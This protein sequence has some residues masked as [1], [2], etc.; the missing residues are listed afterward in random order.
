MQGEVLDTST[1]WMSWSVWLL[2]VTVLLGIWYFSVTG[3]KSRLKGAIPAT[4]G[5]KVSFSSGLLI[6]YLSFGSPLEIL[7]HHYLFS[8]HMLQQALVYFA[9]PPLLLIGIPTWLWEKI[10]ANQTLRNAVRKITNPLFT[11][12]LF[13]ALFS[14]YHVPLFFDM[15]VPNHTLGMIAHSVITISAFMMWWPI[16][17]Q[18]PELVRLTDLQKLGYIFANGVL[19]TPACALIIFA[20]SVIYTPFADVPQL[21]A[22]L[23]P[24][25]DQQLGGVVMKIMQEAIYGSALAYIFFQWFKKENP[26]RADSSKAE[27]D[28]PM[29]IQ[30]SLQQNRS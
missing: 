7:A 26:T 15:L 14:F 20:K 21:V 13:N 23:P 8:A 22:A 16:T 30:P 4:W 24:L 25:D 5:Q 9:M 11:V 29:M 10:L 27:I 1:I 28:P 6:F 3:A 12:I 18:V 2:V 19:I 17:C